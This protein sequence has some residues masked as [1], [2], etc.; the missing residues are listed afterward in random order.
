VHVPKT[1]VDV[2]YFPQS[3]EHEVGRAGEG[4]DM[5]AVTIPKGMN[6]VTDYQLGRSVF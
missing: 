3:R 6:K 1:P 2:D 5:Q 4:S